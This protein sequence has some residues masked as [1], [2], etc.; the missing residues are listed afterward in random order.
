MVKNIYNP[1][2][3]LEHLILADARI[4]DHPRIK[5]NKNTKIIKSSQMS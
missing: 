1:K 2:K 3:V 4:A 5:I